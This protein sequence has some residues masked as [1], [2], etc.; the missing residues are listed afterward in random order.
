[1]HLAR[2]P[3]RSIIER[4]GPKSRQVHDSKTSENRLGAAAGTFL[5]RSRIPKPK[6]M[7]TAWAESFRNRH[8]RTPP[9]ALGKAR[10]QPDAAP[11][12][13]SATTTQYFKAKLEGA[14]DWLL[15]CKPV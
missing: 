5:I 13:V 4:G 3:S 7:V 11:A 8:Y 14:Y 6:T 15:R 10:R 2:T 1:M 12:A 9:R